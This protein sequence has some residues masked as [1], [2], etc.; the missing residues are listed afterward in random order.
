LDPDGRIL[1]AIITLRDVSEQRETERALQAAKVEAELANK[2]KSAFLANM[3]HEIRTPM[4]GVMGM[5]QLA[6]IS[7][8]KPEVRRYLELLQS[9]GKHLMSILNDL[10][11]LAKIESG[12]TVLA[13]KPFDLSTEFTA[14]MEPLAAT[15]RAKGL[16]FSYSLDE[17]APRKLK[18]DAGRFRQ[19]LMNLLSNA[20]KFTS[21][22]KVEAVGRVA[23]KDANSVR[24]DFQ[25]KDTGE[26]IAKEDL[27]Q[28][29]REFVQVR[30]ASRR[31]LGG[32]GLGLAISREL[33]HLMGGDIRVESRLGQGSVFF[34][35][36]LFGLAEDVVKHGK[37]EANT[38]SHPER[39][40]RV[41][42]AED[43]PVN[44]QVILKMLEALGHEA[45]LA[46][47]GRE[48]LDLLGQSEFDMVIMDIRMP[49][50]NGE[51][52]TQAIR[53]GTVPGV[54]RDIPIVALTAY[55]MKGDRER[56]LAMGIDDYLS[57]PLELEQ[58]LQAL[59][60]I[61]ERI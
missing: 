7:D 8:L 33:A 56:L 2:A 24:L 12:K 28:I 5:A 30:P 53:A 21:E 19:V 18:G 6:L 51:E 34:F 40:L 31:T 9:S 45:T 54:R 46:N 41:L 58:L 22:G 50:M 44:Q 32:T 13:V 61:E 10:L 52:T 11:D 27:E 60:Q 38:L 37:L 4:N 47:D 48:A 3:S 17:A 57:K 25:I 59:K 16:E 36:A 43:T 39:P 35:E 23:E 26:G 1:L 29:F 15:A 20:I 55:A 42:V 14:V 49:N